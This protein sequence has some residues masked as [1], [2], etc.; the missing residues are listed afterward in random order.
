MAIKES[1]ISIVMMVPAELHYNAFSIPIPNNTTSRNVMI[2]A[3][4]LM[5][6]NSFEDWLEKID[7]YSLLSECEFV[8][9]VDN[10]TSQLNQ[11][12]EKQ[13]DRTISAHES[14][15]KY[16]EFR[17]CEDKAVTHKRLLE[18]YVDGFIKNNED[19]R[20][21]G[22][23][24][25]LSYEDFKQ[26]LCDA[27]DGS[28]DV[29]IRVNACIVD[30]KVSYRESFKRNDD[31][32]MMHLYYLIGDIKLVTNDKRLRENVNAEYPGRAVTVDEFI[33]VMKK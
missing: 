4:L 30:Q 29:A 19:V 13:I 12:I 24:L 7:S 22:V 31:I 17:Q 28:I 14:I 33:E 32:D 6:A 23:F 10:A 5:S 3:L 27:Y 15:E 25:G 2:M 9:G 11:N 18:H 1:R 26:F 21:V 16:K 20:K 8:K